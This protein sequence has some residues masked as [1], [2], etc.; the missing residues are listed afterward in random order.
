MSLHASAPKAFSKKVCLHILSALSL[1]MFLSCV[2]L[3]SLSLYIYISLSPSTCLSQ[4]SVLKWKGNVGCTSLAATQC[5]VLLRLQIGVFANPILVLHQCSAN[6]SENVTDLPFFKVSRKNG[7]SAI[8][9]STICKE[10]VNSNTSFIQKK[11][12]FVNRRL[13]NPMLILET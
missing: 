4:G 8:P 7:T 3:L 10:L 13:R 11:S 1:Y 2:L 9:C 5:V 12:C 6:C